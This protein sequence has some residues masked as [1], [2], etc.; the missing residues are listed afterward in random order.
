MLLILDTSSIITLLL[1]KHKT[2]IA[3]IVKL[4]HK[5]AILFAVS[6]ET[7]QELG[8]SISVK[9]IKTSKY[10]NE[11]KVGRFIAWYKN[12]TKKY[13]LSAKMPDQTSRDPNDNMFL[14]LAQSSQA[15]YLISVDK[16]LLILKEIGKTKIVTPMGFITEFKK[17]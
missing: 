16:D 13:K 3:S 10:Y 9:K 7:Y 2:Y 5:G 4:G 14:S 8:K 15:D 6:D 12:S 1:S 11:Q 17:K